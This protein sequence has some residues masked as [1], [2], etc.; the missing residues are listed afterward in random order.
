VLELIPDT[1][2]TFAAA[3]PLKRPRLS[4]S[5][6]RDDVLCVARAVLLYDAPLD[7]LARYYDVTERTIRNWI[8]Q[9]LTWDGPESDA[10]RRLREPD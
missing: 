3:R 2:V 6:R 7:R 5:S 4:E 8:D 9:A 1:C 10:L